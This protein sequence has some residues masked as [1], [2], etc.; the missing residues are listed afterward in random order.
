M[1]EKQKILMVH[2]FYQIGGGEHIVFENEKR[3]LRENG[4]E[5]IEYTRSNDELNGSLTKKILMPFTAVFSLKTYREVRSL[6]RKEHID[7]VH[8]QN[9]FPLIS[10]SVYYAAWKCG[11]PA[12]QTV[13]NFR[14]LCPC[15]IFYRD[16]KICQDCVSKGLGEA[17]KRGCYRNSRIQTE[18]VVN[19]LKVHRWL[20]T[21]KKLRY[22]FLTEF[23]R[24]KFRPLL[25]DKVDREFVKP[26]FEYID[27][28]E[29]PETLR[30]F[31]RFVFA[32]RLDENKGVRF[33]LNTWKKI[34]DKKLVIFGTGPLEE[35]VRQAAA[36]NP[37]IEYR[38]FCP[39]KE[40]FEEI[41]RSAAFLFTSEWYE[42]FP[43]T[44]VEVMAL[45]RPGLCS[46]IGNGAD[47]VRNAECDVLYQS[48]CADDFIRGLNRISNPGF[49]RKLCENSR[50]AY[51]AHY[52]PGENYR[53]LKTIYD[54]VCRENGKR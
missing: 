24:E 48:G 36:E 2:N 45:G 9:T 38:G 30:D 41:S 17:L 43:M 39:Q 10:P 47:I 29:L 54:E 32:A 27:I 49:N 23:N 40:I 14:F 8:C 37:M 44:L 28:P 11:I 4:H 16:G 53:I 33:L 1:S 3:L 6:I 12:V 13:H 15:G 5:V 26:N 35:L 46:D 31:Q 25:G 7:I 20:G 50:R 22:I 21:Y 19:M 18:V 52:T 42:G 51:N 34:T